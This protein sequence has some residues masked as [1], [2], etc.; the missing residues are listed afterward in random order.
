MRPKILAAAAPPL[1]AICLGLLAVYRPNLPV[2][3]P[4][5]MRE[6]Q[7][8]CNV[9][10]MEMGT[11]SAK[12]AAVDRSVL[13]DTIFGDMSRTTIKAPIITQLQLG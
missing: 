4:H 3:W 13:S 2:C 5:E 1:A 9:R 8:L 11:E 7:E 12:I 10:Y 6:I